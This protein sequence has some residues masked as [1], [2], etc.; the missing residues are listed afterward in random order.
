MRANSPQHRNCW[1]PAMI[2]CCEMPMTAMTD[3]VGES[4]TKGNTTLQCNKNVWRKGKHTKTSTN[5]S[6]RRLTPSSWGRRA[7]TIRRKNY[8]SC[9]LR[10]STEKRATSKA[11]LII[12]HFTHLIFHNPPCLPMPSSVSSCLIAHEP[13]AYHK[14]EGG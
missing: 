6:G 8:F 9:L 2:Q 13:L 1:A 10:R 3:G 14:R 5:R 12:P 7:H 4:R 11:E